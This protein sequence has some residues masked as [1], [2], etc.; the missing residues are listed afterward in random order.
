MND[1]HR[2]SMNFLKLFDIVLVVLAFGLSTVFIVQEEQRVSLAQFF[3][4]RAKVSDFVIFG[5]ALFLCHLVLCVCGLYR[6]MRLSSRRAEIGNLLPA[7]TLCVSCFVAVGWVFS[8][9]MM[10][11]QFLAVFWALS[12]AVLS[13]ARQVLRLVLGYIRIRGKNLRYLLILGTN[14]RAAEFA[15]RVLA[16]RDSGYRLLG[17]VDDQ[18]AGTTEFNKTGFQV[19]SDNAG[20]ADFLRRN[21]VDEVAIYLPV[22]LLS[23]AIIS[24]LPIFASSMELSCAS[25]RTSSA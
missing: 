24:K 15:R 17:F 22:W 12:T 23:T 20:L 16:S 8:I 1:R 9:R 25:I 2:P 18:W 11:L 19:V 21:V 6:P 4:I 3:S 10:T 14:P 7:A 5:L 13:A